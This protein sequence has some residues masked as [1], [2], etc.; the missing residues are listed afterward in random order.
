MIAT[1]GGRLLEMRASR[2]RRELSAAWQQPLAVQEASLLHL[3]HTARNT[4]FGRQHDFEAIRSVAD[5]Q[6]RVPLR[7]YL[8]FRPLWQ[9]ALDGTPDVTWPGHVRHW[10][11]TSGTTAGDKLIPVTSEMLRSH[12]AGGWD[13]LL[14]AAERVG[15]ARL[16]GGRLL[17]LGSSTDLH[18]AGPDAVVG[19]LSG[20][21]VRAL[22]PGLRRRY[23]PGP[24][25]A[26]IP[27]W[28]TRMTAVA[29][30]LARADLR[31]VA[32]M[33][34]WTL[35]FFDYLATAAC[36]AG[37]P[38]RHVADCWPNFQI[39]IHGGVAFG[40]YR[41]LF[42]ERI[43]R[44]LQRLEVYPASEAFV[45]LQTERSA[46]LTLMIDYGV[47]YEF[48]PVEDLGRQRPRRH[49][50]ADVAIDRPYAVA[51]STPAGLWSYLLGDTVRFIRRDPLTLEITGRTRHFVNAFGE[52]VIGDE[53]ERSATAAARCTG[54]QLT[55]FTVAPVYPSDTE[56]RGGHEWIVEFTRTPDDFQRFV[57]ALDEGLTTINTDYRTKRTGDIGMVAPRML[58]VPAGTF[59]RWMRR[60]GKLG[61]QHKVPRVTNDRALAEALRACAGVAPL[62]VV[63]AP[64]PRGRSRVAPS[65]ASVL[66]GAP[67]PRHEQDQA[68]R[69]DRHQTVTVAGDDPPRLRT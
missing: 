50:V 65:P 47:F 31:L 7:E 13:A 17:F 11:K 12:R 3:V 34:S 5:Y 18:P 62:M 22:P 46:G 36:Q 21:A 10:A 1:I 20:L 59:R 61:D 60:A 42:E 44:P 9:H 53:V 6:R 43:G 66:A 54:A 63:A 16:L 2:R 41:P 29:A 32:G 23:A 35:V 52:N 67:A 57:Q 27:D 24:A 14:L 64:A 56:T 48:I 51:L 26:R 69:P 37:R 33:P 8:D 15:G 40:P 28:E 25:L 49:T 39:F 38:F 45:A 19:D 4:I 30:A 58:V 68:T 55:E